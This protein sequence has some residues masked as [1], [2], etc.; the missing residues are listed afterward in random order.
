VKE[1][2]QFDECSTLR[3]KEENLPYTNESFKEAREEIKTLER[4]KDLTLQTYGGIDNRVETLLQAPAE[5]DDGP[6]GEDILG[7]LFY[8][9][10]CG[11]YECFD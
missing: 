6:K 3:E 7:G 9:T 2:S 1:A 11:M 10:I 4:G 8:G 5:S